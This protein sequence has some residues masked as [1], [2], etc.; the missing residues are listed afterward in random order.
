[1]DTQKKRHGAKKGGAQIALNKKCKFCGK[2][3]IPKRDWQK[4]CSREHQKEYWKR[5][6]NDKVYLLKKIERLEEQIGIK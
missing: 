1:M 6:Q 2:L 4:F 5:V 3:F